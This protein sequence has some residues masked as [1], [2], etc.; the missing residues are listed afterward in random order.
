ML[1]RARPPS[2]VPRRRALLLLVFTALSDPR[3]MPGAIAQ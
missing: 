2:S 1:V 3:L